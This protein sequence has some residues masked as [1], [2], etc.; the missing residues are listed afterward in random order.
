[1]F[2]RGKNIYMND[3]LFSVKD[4]VVV[5]TGISGQ[6]GFEYGNEF[7]ARGAKVVGLDLC[8][9]N[10]TRKL[11]DAYKSNFLYLETDVTEKLSLLSACLKV[12]EIF[13]F[14]DVLI[15]NAAIDSPPSASP[16]ENGPFEN[17][18]ID[19][20]DKVL[21]VNLKGV[22]LSCQVFG[23]EMAKSKGG[24]IINISSIYGVVSPDQS[25]YNYR[26]EKGE[27]FFKPISYS[28]S[29]SG[30]MNLTR[31]LAVYW[32]K[33]GV[34]VNTL[35]LAGVYNGQDNE[36]LNSYNSRIPIGRMANKNE[37]NGALLF[38]ASNASLY[39]TGSSMTI[40]GGW[41]AI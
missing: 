20:W 10:Y 23:S 24:S 26:R 2:S 8:L 16:A 37:Y 36:F 25:I 11:Q 31:Y 22:F 14:V 41:T 40:D 13:G 39:M 19:S 4:K 18:P 9:S 35:V 30:I 1:M 29:K 3:I 38:L 17:Y 28:V 27:I 5:I 15:N 12:N 32:A 33:Q 21:D 6:L 7:L 34:R